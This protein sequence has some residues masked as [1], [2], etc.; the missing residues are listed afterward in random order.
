MSQSRKIAK[1]AAIVAIATLASRILG[2]ARDLIVAFALGAG[3]YADA[4]FVA[5]RIPNLMRRLFGE[6]S[7]TMAFVPVYS[8]TKEQDGDEAAHEMARSALAWLVAILSAITAL[9][10]VFAG[11]LTTAIAPGFTD[12][13]ELFQTTSS[14]VRVCFPY[15][16]FICAV[17]L[18]MGILNSEDHFLAPALAPCV[19]NVCLIAS[20]LLGYF[21]GLNVATAMSVGVLAGG[22]GQW[23]LQQPFLKRKGIS[24]RGPWSWKNPAVIKMGKL[25]IP[26]VF[27]AAVYQINILLSTLLASFLPIGS[28]SY[29]YYADRLVQFPLGVFGDRH[30][31]SGPAQPVQAGCQ[32]PDG[33]LP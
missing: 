32:R 10:M 5:F 3:L 1:N 14:L 19:L 2:F 25:M 29:L 15:T 11:P 16:I 28:I 18:C 23:L 31:H 24:W 8:L 21:A 20:A 12:N 27:G 7:L 4:F 33:R 30:Q 13:P 6:G 9:V 26:T 17:A 22:V